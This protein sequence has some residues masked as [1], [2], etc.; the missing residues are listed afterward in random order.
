MVLWI[1]NARVLVDRERPGAETCAERSSL[2]TQVCG[3]AAK[4][5]ERIRGCDI[6]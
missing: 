3:S 5:A 4:R 1:T 6:S 2:W